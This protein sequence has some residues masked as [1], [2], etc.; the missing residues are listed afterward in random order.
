[1]LNEKDK[2]FIKE[3][4]KITS[5]QKD[6]EQALRVRAREEAGDCSYCEQQIY[7]ELLVAAKHFLRGEGL[8]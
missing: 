5:S 6:L 8:K 2:F 4:I 1:M 3:I 7:T